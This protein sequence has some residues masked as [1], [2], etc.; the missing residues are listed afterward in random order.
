MSDIK[1][2]MRMVGAKSKDKDPF[3]YH[4]THPVAVHDLFL[5]EKFEG[6]VLEPACGEG[7]MSE[8][9]KT[10]GLKVTSWDL[11]D[12]GY[13]DQSRTGD[14]LEAPEEMF[15]NVITN[16][17]FTKKILIPLIIKAIK[18]SRKKTAMLLRLN[19]LE[20]GERKRELFDKYPPAKIY[21]FSYRLPFDRGKLPDI[22]E[23]KD[24]R[25][26]GGGPMAFCW[27]IWDKDHVG[28][29]TSHWI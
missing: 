4:P 6:D 11:F 14:F 13:V 1:T 29:P 21:Y 9:L 24:P 15:D 2:S 25:K 28:P 19:A 23:G 16:P 17:P 3:A 5:Y 18:M 22:P 10:Y 8:V 27:I 7:H 20:G 12:R 26:C